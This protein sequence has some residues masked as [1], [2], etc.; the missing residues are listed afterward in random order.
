M[1]RP[2]DGEGQVLQS[3][4]VTTT[5][6]QRAAARLDAAPPLAA[7]QS[8]PM[9]ARVGNVLVGTASWT[10]RTLLDSGA[11]YPPGVTTPADRLRYY[12]RHFPVVEVD[13]TFYAL[14]AESM[15]RA[16]VTRVPPDFVFGVKAFAALTQHPF[17]PARLPSDLRTAI[18]G[19]LARR[20]RIYPRELPPEIDVEIWRRFSS[21]LA[22][23]HEADLLGYVLLQFPK[24]FPR[25]PTSLAYLE[26]CAAR[27][28]Y[29]L[30]IEFRDPSWL[31]EGRAER[32]F[33]FLRA[34]GLAYVSVDEPQGTPASVPPIAEATSDELAV[35]RFH[36]RNGD[37]W[38]RPGVST[39]EKFGYQYTPAELREWQPRIE[40]LATQ[41][42][43]VLVLMNNCRSHYAVQNAKELATMLTAASALAARR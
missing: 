30:A 36:G 12:A 11:F 38:N 27:L 9:P 20:P 2:I 4:N 40:R 21:A 22:P 16:W 10:E 35:V 23:L 31:A 34:R 8:G 32:T 19:T 33:E 18:G 41:T 7:L 39:V 37:V 14:P 43:R 26:S 28:P 1:V 5:R 15:A 13:A 29:P 24:W 3:G 17:V 25:S 6:A 42:R